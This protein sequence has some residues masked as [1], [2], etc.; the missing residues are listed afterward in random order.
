MGSSPR[1]MNLNFE[2]R[3]TIAIAEFTRNIFATPTTR[4]IYYLPPLPI[5]YN[6]L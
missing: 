1:G 4:P 2:G 3:V 5:L 6:G